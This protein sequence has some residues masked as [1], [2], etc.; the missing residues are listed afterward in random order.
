MDEPVD[1]TEHVA[2]PDTA[3]HAPARPGRGG[4]GHLDPED[5]GATAVR[6]SVLVVGRGVGPVAGPLGV[7]AVV[8]LRRFGPEAGARCPE[9]GTGLRVP[10]GRPPRPVR[11]TLSPPR[12][13]LKASTSP[14]SVSGDSGSDL[15][16]TKSR[17][18]ARRA[19]HRRTRG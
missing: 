8:T 9:P 19:P 6:L 13:C 2:G 5:T 7:R 14:G 15:Q 18:P 16:V 10:R 11:R 4:R 1:D 3:T 17:R 12:Q